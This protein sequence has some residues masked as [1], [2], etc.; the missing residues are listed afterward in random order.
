M[1]KTNLCIVSL[2]NNRLGLLA[3]YYKG[4]QFHKRVSVSTNVRPYLD[5]RVSVS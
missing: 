3:L 1:V 2:V 4:Y 5:E